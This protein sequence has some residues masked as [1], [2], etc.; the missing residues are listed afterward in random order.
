[1][2]TAT[3]RFV[4]FWFLVLLAL[5]GGC[6]VFISDADLGTSGHECYENGECSAG[7]ICAPEVRVCV[8][9]CSKVMFNIYSSG[10]CA[11]GD[12]EGGNL[13]QVEASS[14]CASDMLAAERCGCIF[15][16]V[17]LLE[18]WQEADFG[19]GE[20]S[21]WCRSEYD[22]YNDCRNHYCQ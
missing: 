21:S 3:S 15:E 14:E 19:Y 20:C 4:I 17:Y 5:T 9:S 13:T 1:M 10:R 11:M 8:P 2:K 12:G 16:F 6:D 7:Y 18:C 22:Q